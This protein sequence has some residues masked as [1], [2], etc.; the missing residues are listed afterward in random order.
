[1]WMIPSRGSRDNF[2][3]TVIALMHKR[4]EILRTYDEDARARLIDEQELNIAHWTGR[5]V[6]SWK[7]GVFWS[8][9]VILLYQ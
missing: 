4:D 1:M 2:A 3:L 7:S 5:E 6:T 8:R 9:L